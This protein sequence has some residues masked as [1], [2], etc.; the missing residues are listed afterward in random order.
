[1]PSLGADAE[2]T[3]RGVSDPELRNGSIFFLA[4][5]LSGDDALGD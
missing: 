1:M 4:D 5:N 3:E 2:P